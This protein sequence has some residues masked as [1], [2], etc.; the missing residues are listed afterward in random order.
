MTQGLDSVFDPAR[1][2]VVGAS[3]QPGKVGTKFIENLDSFDGEVIP[4]TPSRPVVAGRTAYPTLSEIPGGVDL[5]VA[6]L[7]AE[8]VLG[9]V[10]DAGR[11]GVG[12]VV[13]ISGG[14]AETGPEGAKL[15][16]EMVALARAGDV[17]I[18]GPN[19]LGVQ[20]CHSGLNA[21]MALGTSGAGG[22]ISLATQSGAY[23]MAIYMLGREQQ[24]GFAKVYAAG[25]KADIA[26]SEVLDY[27][28][29]DERSRILC[30][31]IE[32]LDDGRQFV[33]AARGIAADKPILVTKTGRTE[34]GARA[35]VSHTAALAGQA[36]VL[37]AAFAQTGVMLV[38]NG[39]EMIDVAK[40]LDWQ[41]VPCGPRVGLITNSGGTGVEL[42]DLLSEEGLVVPELSAGL[43]RELAEALPAFGSARNP[44]DVTTAWDRFAELY[45]LALDRLARSGEVD[46]VVPVLLQRSAQD[47]DVAEGIRDTTVALAADGVDVPVYACWVAPEDAKPNADLLQGSQVPCFSWPSRTAR[48]AGHAHR[49]RL[50]RDTVR[51]PVATIEPAS[52]LPD[53]DSGPLDPEAAAALARGFGIDVA[54]QSLVAGADDAADAAAS[55]GFPVVAKLVSPRHVHKSDV[56]GVRVGLA[57]ALAV[58]HAT[59]ELLDIDADGAIL[60]QPMVEGLELIVG[61]FRDPQFGP[62]VMGG[63]GG[64]FVE[65]LGDAAFRLA[66]IDEGEALDALRSLRGAAL[67]DGVRGRAG[68]DADRVAATVAAVSQM[69]AAVH[70]IEEIDLNPVI[71][72]E[73]GAVAVDVR[74][75]G[76]SA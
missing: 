50:A 69:I 31:F 48:A 20:N 58:S 8:A 72:T 33:D 52:D 10:E 5:A 67:L 66:P 73:T 13:V 22:R 21:T 38:D 15:Q 63:L 41:P 1:V 61:G 3:D 37:R 55:L 64:V 70:E 43:Q 32:S 7:P 53:V 75:V 59:A 74:I 4:V 35:A 51:A 60:V 57:D 54:E 29:R 19:C 62:V 2:A 26:D 49:Y 36:E 24:M 6:V 40:A 34:A 76:A 68:V 46:I 65:V 16:D 23:G 39:L 17:R 27:F 42:T 45:P 11:A 18:V 9:V 28:G 44:V 56:G 71:A 47:R 12:A 30:F 25:N 14:F